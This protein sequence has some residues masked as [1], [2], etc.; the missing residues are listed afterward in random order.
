MYFNSS[1]FSTSLDDQA[2]LNAQITADIAE[3]VPEGAAEIFTELSDIATEVSGYWQQDDFESAT[4][5]FQRA[6]KLIRQL[7]SKLTDQTQQTVVKYLLRLWADKFADILKSCEGNTDTINT[8]Y[9]E[10]NFIL[11]AL[12]TLG[13]QQQPPC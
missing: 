3:T 12:V 9:T 13:D 6:A 2:A 4:E 1:T 5:P 8:Y 10:L 11:R 7:N